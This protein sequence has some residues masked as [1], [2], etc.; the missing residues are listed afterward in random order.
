MPPAGETP[1]PAEQT[2]GAKTPQNVKS[3]RPKM[4]LKLKSPTAATAASSTEPPTPQTPAEI[5][6]KIMYNKDGK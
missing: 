1:K 3:P 4:E 5:R 2:P 6:E